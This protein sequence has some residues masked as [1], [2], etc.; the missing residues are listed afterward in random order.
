VAVTV[1]AISAG[2]RHSDAKEVMAELE[3]LLRRGCG[4]GGNTVVWPH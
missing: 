1:A 3:D 2:F 4:A